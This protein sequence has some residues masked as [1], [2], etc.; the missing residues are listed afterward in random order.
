MSRIGI[1]M[2][3]S[4]K[5]KDEISSLKI[6]NKL[7]ALLELSSI[8]KVNASISIRNAFINIS[9]STESL[10][11]AKRIYKLIYF[12]Y[13]YEC[14]ITRT[15]NNALQKNGIYILIVE[16]EEVSKKIM[17]DCA[18]DIYGN[19]TVDSNIIYSRIISNENKGIS[20][21]LRGVFLGAG[22]IV[23]PKKSYHLEMIITGEEDVK[24]IQDL[25]YKVD[26]SSLY[27]KRKDKHVIYIKSSEMIS[28]F[29]NIIGAN[30]ALL[31]LEN[32][33]IEKDLR[34]NVNRR[35]N[36]DIA[37]INKT[38]QTSLS[39]IEDIEY[40][41]SLGEMPDN[42]KEVSRLR[43]ENPE[44]TLKQIADLFNPPI[45]KSN[46][47]YRFKKIKELAKKLRENE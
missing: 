41:E 37:N 22:S 31:E 1:D 30:R 16:S 44:F 9:F 17:E 6:D 19:Y 36:F 34:N 42:L 29:L 4:N 28:D 10:E 47:S 32:V 12:L 45:S 27:N 15:E 35:M 2:T 39:Q 43:K 23:D 11:V 21:F 7:E 3:F 25:L 5:V 33:K 46:V 24:L 14:V 38:I 8:L 18:Y 40:I 26:I 20:S 13:D